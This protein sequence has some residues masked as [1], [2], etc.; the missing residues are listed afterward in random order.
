MYVT[1]LQGIKTQALHCLNVSC[2]VNFK[3][4]HEPKQMLLDTIIYSVCGCYI[5][6]LKLC[7]TV[8][9]SNHVG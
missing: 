5:Y 6:F 9:V 2:Q 7:L 4:I 3:I 1:I 8:F